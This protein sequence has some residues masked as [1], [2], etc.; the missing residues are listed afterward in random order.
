M[1]RR[2]RAGGE[3]HVGG[4]L[5]PDDGVGGGE[6]EGAAREAEEGPPA[7]RF[8]AARD[9]ARRPRGGPQ[10]RPPGRPRRR[11]LPRRGPPTTARPP[12]TR[13]A[14]RAA[15]RRGS[16]CRRQPTAA[17]E[18][19]GAGVHGELGR[20]LPP[21]GRMDKGKGKEKREEKGKKKEKNLE[22]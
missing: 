7:T 21:V 12:A 22:K 5:D 8:A 2:E 19:A 9:E 3:E 14:A 10:P 13:S 6:V 18:G 20:L 1:G 4:G 11:P 16:R 15:A 17:P